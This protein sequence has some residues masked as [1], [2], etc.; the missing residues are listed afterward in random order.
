MPKNLLGLQDKFQELSSVVPDQEMELWSVVKQ[1]A[2]RYTTVPWLSASV[3]LLDKIRT[4]S[5]FALSKICGS[6]S[7]SFRTTLSEEEFLANF[8]NRDKLDWEMEN[9]HK[10]YFHHNFAL[11]YWTLVREI[12][13]ESVYVCQSVFNLPFG[14]ISTLACS[15]F[16]DVKHF[17][18]SN[19]L[20]RQR[21]CLVSPENT[22]LKILTLADSQKLTPQ[23]LTL[24]RLTK[25]KKRK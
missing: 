1:G 23:Q 11:T 3:C 25:L 22:Y 19:F 17:C 9:F 10:F 4:C 14:I 18:E 6:V 12:A 20:T 2:S 21:F 15:T 8:G 24:L 16:T 13:K 5:P 7:C